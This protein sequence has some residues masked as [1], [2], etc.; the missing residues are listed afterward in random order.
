MTRIQTWQEQECDMRLHIAGLLVW[1][2]TC[3]VR[4]NSSDKQPNMAALAVTRMH[5]Q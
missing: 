4:L 5:G 2:L 3:V 1:L